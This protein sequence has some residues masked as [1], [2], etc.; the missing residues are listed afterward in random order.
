MQHLEQSIADIAAIYR[1]D[2]R[3]WVIGY[4]GGKDSTAVVRL[5]F[6]ALA[7][8]A[9]VERRKSVFVVSSD[10]LVETPLVVN[11]IRKTLAD[12]RAAAQALGLPIEV[13][14]PVTPKLEQ[15]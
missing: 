14:D 10:T 7:S 6:E 2:N 12:I 4:S 11:L 15:T 8:M 5:V 3:P 13:A 9:P 1:A